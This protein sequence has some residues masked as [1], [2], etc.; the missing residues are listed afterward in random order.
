MKYSCIYIHTHSERLGIH[1]LFIWYYITLKEKVI[2]T[3][4]LRVLQKCYMFRLSHLILV[5]I[6][7]YAQSLGHVW[8]SLFC[9]WDFSG[10]NTRVG[11]YLLSRVPSQ[12]KDRTHGSFTGRW[13]LYHWATQEAQEFNSPQFQMSP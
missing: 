5:Q 7:L 1:Y 3:K 4:I 11:C 9:P 10:K 12:P 13:I 8:F 2:I 6:C